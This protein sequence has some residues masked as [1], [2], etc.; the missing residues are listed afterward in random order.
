MVDGSTLANDDLAGIS[1]TQDFIISVPRE[2]RV[3]NWGDMGQESNGTPASIATNL[4]ASPKL[5]SF[6]RRLLALVIRLTLLSTTE[7]CWVCWVSWEPS[8]S[9][10]STEPILL[11]LELQVD[12]RLVDVSE[13]IVTCLNTTL[14]CSV[15]FSVR[16]FI[17][18]SFRFLSMLLCLMIREALWSILSAVFCLWKRLTGSYRDDM[19]LEYW[20]LIGTWDIPILFIK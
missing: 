1:C 18:C 11:L 9:A 8:F 19:A 20:C 3:L 14:V 6:I 4:W 16:C 2:I 12:P 13:F 7:F 15:I 5:R 17:G 10:R